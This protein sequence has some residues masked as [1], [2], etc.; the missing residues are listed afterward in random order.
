MSGKSAE[1][2]CGTGVS[3][4]DNGRAWW[5]NTQAKEACCQTCLTSDDVMPVTALLPLLKMRLAQLSKS[6]SMCSWM[7]VGSAVPSTLNS[8]SSEM[9]KNLHEISNVVTVH[10]IQCQ[11]KEASMAANIRLDSSQTQAVY[12][13]MLPGLYNLHLYS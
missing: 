1:E 2:S 13:L 6:F 7:L 11:S 8:S 5:Y 4:V 9:K 10:M 3:A 12:R